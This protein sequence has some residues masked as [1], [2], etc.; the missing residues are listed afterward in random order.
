[1]QKIL[2]TNDYVSLP[3]LGSIVRKYESAHLADDGKTLLPP[4][5]FFAF[6]PS[7]S[8]NDEALEN[9]LEASLGLS[10]IEASKKVEEYCKNIQDR[11]KNNETVHFPGIG[12]LRSGFGGKIELVADDTL[13]TSAFLPTIDVTAANQKAAKVESNPKVE[14]QSLSQPVEVKPK[15]KEKAKPLRI[16]PS[17]T[18]PKSSKPVIAS[19]LVLVLVVAIGAAFVFVPELRFWDSSKT[20]NKAQT[21]SV[22]ANETNNSI[23]KQQAIQ[24]PKSDSVPVESPVKS[25]SVATSSEIEAK[26]HESFLVPIDKKSALLYRDKA[27]SERKTYYIV[28][29]SFASRDN[30]QKLIDEVSR[31]GYKPFILPGNNGYRVVIFQ[32]TNRDRALRELERVRGLHLTSQAWL[33]TL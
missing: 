1:V 6:D 16:E 9:Y 29:G 19:L 27:E 12:L 10:K 25:E 14:K 30:A 22:P 7:R 23:A 3:G 8:F 20:E 13:V 2:Q 5:E 31:L 26:Q 28:I 15:T 32:F 18:S 21:I 11:L 33:L 4:V 24:E 17:V